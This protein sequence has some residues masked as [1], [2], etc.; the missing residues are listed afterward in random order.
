MDRR[1]VDKPEGFDLRE[2]RAGKAKDGSLWT[3]ED[4][5]FDAAEQI[6]G[7]AVK[8]LLV[9]WVVEEEGGKL[10]FSY[11][12]STTSLAERLLLLRRAERMFEEK[13]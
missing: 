11:S 9:C 4:A 7:K 10:T 13:L 12:Q 2:K 6:K 5:L 8:Q 3:P 1:L